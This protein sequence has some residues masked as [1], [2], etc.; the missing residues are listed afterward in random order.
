MGAL[1]GLGSQAGPGTLVHSAVPEVSPGEL[2][3]DY[4]IVHYGKAYLDVSSA[5]ISF[6]G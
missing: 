1:P 3:L 5:R 4:Y 2:T 6:N